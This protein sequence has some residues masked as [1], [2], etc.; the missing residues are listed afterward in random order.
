MK[1]QAGSSRFDTVLKMLLI[2][3][4]SLLAFSSGVYFG[5]EMTENDY[6][7]K[8]LEADYNTSKE[9]AAEKNKDFDTH[10][11]EA[12]AA[13]DIDALSEKFVNAEHDNL[14]DVV[15]EKGHGADAAKKEKSGKHSE[16]KTNGHSEAKSSGHG[17]DGHAQA[18]AEHGDAPKAGSHS[19]AKTGSHSEA[20]A[21]PH[22]ET[23]PVAEAPHE[24][25]G[26]KAVAKAIA[27]AK[28]GTHGGESRN[29]ASAN[30]VKSIVKENVPQADAEAD[31]TH[32]AEK[33]P[34]QAH[35]KSQKPDLGAV[36][37]AAQRVA[38]NETPTVAAKVQ[39]ETRVPSSLP[40][41]VGSAALSEFTV[42]VA[43]Y[44]TLDEA[45]NHANDL[46]KKGFPAY[47]V[48][49]NVKGKVWYRVS[50][51]SFKTQKEAGTYRAQLIKQANLSSAIVQKID[52]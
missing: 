8:A 30:S 46:V 43:S 44:P 49:A 3:F 5:R 28:K 10:E 27:E 52:R 50:V 35:T 1:N 11:D 9:H 33:N 17:D 38:N 12:V 47:P 21:N 15:T 16:G 26:D 24:P 29:L 20:K 40:K 51:G 36:H 23:K 37:E 7:L 45:K 32:G 6:Q 19:E 39:T 48:E 31:F 14:G 18:K 42:Q 13:E 25:H 34:K 2:A 22:V 41:S 4:I